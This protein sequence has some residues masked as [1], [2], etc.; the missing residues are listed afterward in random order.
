MDDCNA[1]LC[2][3][4]RAF[5]HE[6]TVNPL[7]VKYVDGTVPLLACLEDVYRLTCLAWARPEDCMRD[8]I[9]IKLTDR[10]LGEDATTF[11][12]DALEFETLLGSGGWN[13]SDTGLYSNWYERIRTIAELVDQ[14]LLELQAKEP[15][16]KSSTILKDVL[17]KPSTSAKLSRQVLTMLLRDAHADV[18]LPKLGVDLSSQDVPE[19]AIADLKSSLNFWNM[20][21]LTPWPNSEND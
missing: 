17:T 2:A 19:G 4:G 16:R 5:F 1:F 7:H 15:K 13:M 14:A 10:R 20:K 11:D 3:T 9:T 21:E 18:N 8:P 12:E 6:G